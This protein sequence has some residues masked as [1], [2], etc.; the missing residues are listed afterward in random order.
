MTAR[1][2]NVPEELF[3]DEPSPLESFLGRTRGADGKLVP[4]KAKKK[5][6][7]AAV[8]GK[9]IE[10]TKVMIANGDFEGCGARHLV[11]LYSLMHDKVYGVEPVMSSSERH[12]AVLRMGGFVKH[13]F[14]GDFQQA[15]AFYRWVWTRE[16][17]REKWRRENKREGSRLSIGLLMSGSIITDYRVALSRNRTRG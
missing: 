9:A 4:R 5:T 11:A 17:G 6:F 16:I 8:F 13:H 12:T 10:E 7:A 15:V 2:V 3:D 14:G 1:R